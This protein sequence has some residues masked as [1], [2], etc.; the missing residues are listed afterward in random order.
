MS[1]NSQFRRRLGRTRKGKGGHLSVS[2]G[3][4]SASDEVSQTHASL[5]KSQ[6]FYEGVQ[7]TL[8]RTVRGSGLKNDILGSLSPFREGGREATSRKGEGVARKETR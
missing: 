4:R 6:N 7:T 8:V 5:K 2:G 3:G 1:N